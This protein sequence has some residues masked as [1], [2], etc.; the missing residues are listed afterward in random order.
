MSSQVLPLTRQHPVHQLVSWCEL[1][2]TRQSASYNPAPS[3]APP[4]P[5]PDTEARVF[6]L[7]VG[8]GHQVMMIM[9]M[10]M[11]IIMMI[12]TR[13]WGCCWRLVAALPSTV[14]SSG[15]TPSTWTRWV[16]IN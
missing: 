13:C 14:Q 11:I 12:M 7:V 1:F 6:L 8:L 3:P 10:I 4:H 15:Q 2:P 16:T 5:G 9:I